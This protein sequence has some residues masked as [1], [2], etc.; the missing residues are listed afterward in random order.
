MQM[1]THTKQQPQPAPASVVAED[2]P[3]LPY[4]TDIMAFIASVDCERK[5]AW[6]NQLEKSY[7]Q[8]KQEE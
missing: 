7:N 3:P 4:Y 1:Q 2:A 6:I 8:D 5:A